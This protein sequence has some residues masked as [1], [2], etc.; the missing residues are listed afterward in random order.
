VRKI[1]HREDQ[2]LEGEEKRIRTVN[3][4]EI[5]ENASFDSIGRRKLRS[6][7]LEREKGYDKE[8]TLQNDTVGKGNGKSAEKKVRRR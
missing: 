6:D 1:L 5:F 4:G 7:K 8:N 2:P 3:T